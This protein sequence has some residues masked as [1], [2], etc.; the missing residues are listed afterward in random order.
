MKSTGQ[1][2]IKNG[3]M[4]KEVLEFHFPPKIVKNSPPAVKGAIC[5]IGN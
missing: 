5:I 1:N 4:S 3:K 2:V